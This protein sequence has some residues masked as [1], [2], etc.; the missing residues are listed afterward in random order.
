MFGMHVVGV[1]YGELVAVFL[2]AERRDQRQAQHDGKY[3]CRIAMHVSSLNELPNKLIN[4][5][6]PDYRREQR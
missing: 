3:K 5:L 6:L 1:H 4:I 2:G